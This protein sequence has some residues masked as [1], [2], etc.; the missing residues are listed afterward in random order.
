[1]VLL[2][3]IQIQAS[4][5]RQESRGVFSRTDFP[6]QDDKNWK[7]NLVFWQKNGEILHRE[8]A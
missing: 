6:K 4:L 3:E 1:M 7:K 8:Q 5:L 2:A